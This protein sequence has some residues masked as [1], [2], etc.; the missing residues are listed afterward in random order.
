MFQEWIES[1]L[2]LPLWVTYMSFFCN[3]FYVNISL[4]QYQNI[5]ICE[6]LSTVKTVYLRLRQLT[7]FLWKPSLSNLRNGLPAV[8]SDFFLLHIK[9][10]L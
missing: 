2:I 6:I 7:L 5:W 10:R 3:Q 8:H 4:L 1:V 9:W